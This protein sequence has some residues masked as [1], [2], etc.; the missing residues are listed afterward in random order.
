MLLELRQIDPELAQKLLHTNKHRIIRAMEVYYITGKSLT[1][2]QKENKTKICF[3]PVIFGLDCERKELYKKIDARVFTMINNGLIKEVEGL[4]N[5]GF[6][7][8]LKAFR[9]VG[10][11]EPIDHLDDKISYETMIG[12]I[13][14]YSR[15]Y[16]KR[17]LTWFRADER[18]HWLDTKTP[19]EQ[20]LEIIIK[21][22]DENISYDI[23]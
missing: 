4:L 23:L 3:Y 2:L 1:T 16:A 12:Q 21:K 20:L 17:Q 18:I 10:Y 5:M 13:Q 19:K 11:K 6:S 15:N 22:F 14:Q 9:T 7:R 8:D